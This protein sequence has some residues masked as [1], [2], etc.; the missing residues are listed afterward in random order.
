MPKIGRSFRH[1]AFCDFDASPL[2]TEFREGKRV[3]M[4]AKAGVIIGDDVTVGD[5]VTV[6]R[7]VKQPTRVGDRVYL[8]HKVNI[9]HDCQI[10]AGTVINVGAVLC[11]EVTVGED[12]YIAPGAVI[13]PRCRIGKYVEIGTMSN[14]IHDTVIPD[15]EVWFGNP[16]K[17][18]RLNTWRP[19]A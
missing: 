6:N 4:P 7:G 9:G 3:L 14:V 11:G 12:T 18:Q 17:R 1:G 16:A 5:H 15:G 8:W 2:M 19:P 13:Q 10:G